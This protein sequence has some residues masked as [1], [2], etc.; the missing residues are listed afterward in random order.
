MPRLRRLQDK[1]ASA[2]SQSSPSAAVSELCERC[3]KPM[4]QESTSRGDLFPWGVLFTE[5][6][7][8]KLSRQNFFGANFLAFNHTKN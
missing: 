1:R 5:A 4:K 3:L 7:A 6:L 2:T 8:G